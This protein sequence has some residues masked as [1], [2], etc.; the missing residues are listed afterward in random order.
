M[1]IREKYWKCESESPQGSKK[2]FLA[3]EKVF[4]KE[5]TIE[6]ITHGG[7]WMHVGGSPSYIWE[8]KLFIGSIDEYNEIADSEGWTI[9]NKISLEKELVYVA[10]EAQEKED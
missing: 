7:T 1:I 2:E 3:F 6:T 10:Y 8:P 4:E 5:G 9:I